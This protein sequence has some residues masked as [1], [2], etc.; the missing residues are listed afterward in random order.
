MEEV[1]EEAGVDIKYREEGR[2]SY[3]E[4]RLERHSA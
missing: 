4:K 2:R 3:N 1:L